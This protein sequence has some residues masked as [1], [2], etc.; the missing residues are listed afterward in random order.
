[1]LLN[2]VWM[3]RLRGDEGLDACVSRKIE[4]AWREENAEFKRF[5]DLMCAVVELFRWSEKGIDFSIHLCTAA[6]LIY[7]LEYEGNEKTSWFATC[8]FPHRIPAFPERLAVL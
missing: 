1:M 2:C 8:D 7:A 4:E 6:D 3:P 5:R